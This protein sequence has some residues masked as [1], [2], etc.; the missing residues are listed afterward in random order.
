MLAISGIVRNLA[1]IFM[2]DGRGSLVYRTDQ[3]LFYIQTLTFL[4][5]ASISILYPLLSKPKKIMTLPIPPERIQNIETAVLGKRNSQLN[6][7][8]AKSIWR[9][10]WLVR[11]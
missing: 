1:E 2:N 7:Y 9:I 11:R 10:L 8:R 6:E 3:A 5:G 4:I